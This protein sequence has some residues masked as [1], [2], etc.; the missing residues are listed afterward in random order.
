MTWKAGKLVLLFLTLFASDLS[1]CFTCLKTWQS[2]SHLELKVVN[3]LTNISWKLLRRFCRMISLKISI[4][5]FFTYCVYLFFFEEFVSIVF[6]VFFVGVMKPRLK[7]R[8][9]FELGVSESCVGLRGVMRESGAESLFGVKK[10]KLLLKTWVVLYSV[11]V[12]ASLI[13]LKLLLNLLI[14][15]SFIKYIFI[16]SWRSSLLV[17]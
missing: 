14:G 15:F 11:L 10:N 6:M 8:I 12:L 1:V 7:S 5:F 4:L 17:S 9:L 2:T 3:S 13:D 16:L